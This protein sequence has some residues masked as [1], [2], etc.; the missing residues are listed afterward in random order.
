MGRVVLCFCDERLDICPQ[1][2]RLRQCG[3]DPLVRDQLAGQVAQQRTAVSGFPAQIFDFV[4]VT[5]DC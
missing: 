1:G 5:H 3:N 2:L 4:S